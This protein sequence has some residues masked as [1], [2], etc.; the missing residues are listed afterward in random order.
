MARFEIPSTALH[1]VLAPRRALLPAAQ[2]S[3]VRTR[4]LQTSSRASYVRPHS[5]LPQCS[6][7]SSHP[8]ERWKGCIERFEPF[9]TS[10]ALKSRPEDD[11][12]RPK[13]A[14]ESGKEKV[15]SD[16]VNYITQTCFLPFN[17]ISL[18]LQ[19]VSSSLILSICSSG[20]E[21]VV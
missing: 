18:F 12:Q 15:G 14:D 19:K 6:I 9:S 5:R 21:D 7:A 13:P 17:F 20:V 11:V 3:Q 16:F 2:P 8:K 4:F 10:L 1:L